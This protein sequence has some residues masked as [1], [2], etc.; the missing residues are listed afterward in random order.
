MSYYKIIM[1][2]GLILLGNGCAVFEPAPTPQPTP[3]PTLPPLA[4]AADV[5]EDALVVAIPNDPPSFNAYLN[6]TGYEALIGELVFG[7]LA[8]I[9]PDG[10][11]YAELAREL[12]TL[13]N[14]GLSP[15][16]LTVTWHLRPDIQWSDGEP[17]T[18]QDVYFTWRAL[19]D[20]GIWA[21][22]FALIESIET[23][24]PLTAIV[25]YREFYPHYLIQFGGQGTGVLPA[26]QC[27]ATSQMLAWDCNLEPVS[28]GPFV[29][30]QWIPGVRLIFDPNPNYFVPDRPLAS[31]LIFEIESDPDVRQRSL[32]R[33]NVH[34]DLWVE[35]PN[36]SR[37]RDS[38]G[39]NILR[40]DPPRFVLRL[41]SNLS[42]P[43]TLD[44]DIPHPILADERVRRAIR[45][46]IEVGRLNAEA[47]NNQGVPVDTEL[48][49]FDCDIPR[50]D[51]NPSLAAALLDEA[52][53]VF[54][55]P[56]DEVRRCQGCGTAEEGSPMQLTS[57]TYVEY[58][59][60]MIRAHRLIEEMLA[61]SGIQLERKVVEGGKLWD[62]WADGGIEIHGRFDLDL[63]DDGYYGVDPTIY[64]TDYFDP[65]SIPTRHNPIAG[66]NFSRYHNP[67]LIDLFDAL[68]TPLPANRRRVLLCELA[69]ILYQDLPHI[70]LLALPDI[71]AAHLDLQNVLPHIY[72]TVTWNAAE[73]QLV[74]PVQEQP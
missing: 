7:A 61:E 12:P 39:A 46:A 11:Y 55:D 3:T 25:H 58:G 52:G 42:M 70:P 71:Y 9:G 74:S 23:P 26:H 10:H 13:A 27:G 37:L 21:P 49:R 17:F 4:L 2:I 40:T 16:G 54:L 36:L 72:D 5:R 18:S 65:R 19:Y 8:E 57:Y 24:D 43:D 59:P 45:H 34:L 38:G 22:G 62:T 63:W 53:W 73:W 1:M 35:E 47:F 15:D 48:F 6:D 64:L 60:Q 32:V 31:Q 50:Y 14:G 56:E 44:P 51:Y 30:A 41:V 28:T 68:H 66:L 29:L 67:A 20:S 69:I 33:G